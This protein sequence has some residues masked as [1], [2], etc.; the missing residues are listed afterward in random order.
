[1]RAATKR[2]HYAA[3]AAVN[4][5]ELLPFVMETY[6]G[7][8]VEANKVIRYLA[9]SAQHMQQ[10]EFTRHAHTCLSMALQ[11][12]NA[13]V[14]LLGQQT[15]QCKRQLRH[16][17]PRFREAAERARHYARQTNATTLAERMQPEIS[18]IRAAGAAINTQEAGAEAEAE[19][20][21]T[22]ASASSPPLASLSS[23]S[24]SSSLSFIHS[25]LSC[26]ADVGAYFSDCEIEPDAESPCEATADQ[27][28]LRRRL[29]AAAAS[30]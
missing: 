27:R 4:Q 30:A 16:R 13:A 7:F 22:A 10:R 23:R 29:M 9:A 15:L 12:G 24:D 17:G 25:R 14:A 26:V 18:A 1:M 3:I 11:R 6:G 19:I 28:D 5:Y 2:R 20:D 8:G 21:V